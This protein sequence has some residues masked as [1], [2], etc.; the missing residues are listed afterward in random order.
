MG[1]SLLLRQL[2]SCSPPLPLSL[3]PGSTRLHPLP[4]ISYPAADGEVRHFDLREPDAG[5][6]RLLACRNLHGR[7]ELNS[8][9]CQ[10]GSSSPQFCVAGGDA[11]VRWVGR[12][13]ELA[14][15]SLHR[16]S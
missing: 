16:C 13:R 10:P 11:F 15:R 6:R 3:P 5:A 14:V 4:H 1:K 12:G 8:V 9:H 2:G 7:L